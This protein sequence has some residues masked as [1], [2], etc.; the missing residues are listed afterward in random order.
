MIGK[1]LKALID[2]NGRGTQARLSEALSETAVNINRWTNGTRAIPTEAIPKLADFFGVSESYFLRDDEQKPVKKVPVYGTS[3]C[4]NTEDNHSQEDNKICYYNGEDWNKSMY[5]VIANGDSMA[6]EIEN[7]DEIICDPTIAPVSGDIVNY[8]IL[9]ESAVKVVFYDTDINIVQFIPYNQ[10]ENFKT[11]SVRL[12][13][14]E[15][16][17]LK[18]HKVVAINKFKF[19][20]RA[21]RL[22]LVGR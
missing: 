12:D 1:K 21:A 18:I 22:K 15:I 17:D 10:T 8:S 19:N 7:G 11:R 3:S 5:C 16:N 6:P 2:E 14:D 9:G 4:G 20:N 13:D